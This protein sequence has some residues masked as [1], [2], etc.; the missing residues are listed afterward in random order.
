MSTLIKSIACYSIGTI[1]ADD[2]DSFCYEVPTRKLMF[3]IDCRYTLWREKPLIIIV[4]TDGTEVVGFDIEA[5]LAS[6]TVPTPKD[7]LPANY[8][9]RRNLKQS[10]EPVLCLMQRMDSWERYPDAINLLKLYEA[11][12]DFQRTVDNICQENT[13]K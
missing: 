6:I 12:T 10:F 7:I 13:K 4:L 2:F 1:T 8:I 9:Q 11:A 5:M 3:D